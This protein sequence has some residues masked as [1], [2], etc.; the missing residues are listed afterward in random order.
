MDAYRAVKQRLFD[1]YGKL[2]A[3]SP[4][5][6][7]IN[8]DDP[9]GAIYAKA[10]QEAGFDV[11]T[12]GVNSSDSKVRAKEIEAHPSETKFQV[13][14]KGGQTYPVTLKIGGL[15]N[16]SNALAAIA[17][18]RSRGV[19]VEAVQKGLA[20]LPHVPGRFEPVPTGDLGFHAIVDYAHTP[21]GLENLLKSAKALN[22]KRIICVFG[23][24]GDRDRTKRPIMGR[25]ASELADR[26]VITSDNPRT[27][28][29]DFIIE[30]IVAG[31][32]PE[33]IESKTVIEPDRSEAIRIAILNEAKPG[34]LV[35][36]AGKGHETYQ[37]VGDRIFH[38]DDREK[39]REA[40]ALWK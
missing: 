22:P 1:D 34:D 10:A 3:K 37:I 25:L 33:L 27:E 2:Y 12:Y 29:P 30:E 11:W 6:A 19:S 40:I 5:F 13:V 26:V 16:V 38:F 31:I 7:S 28:D 35:V 39:V 15:F 24:G 36:I 9:T 20:A 4:R 8:S 21:D 32:D 18:V 14:E 23:C 17:A